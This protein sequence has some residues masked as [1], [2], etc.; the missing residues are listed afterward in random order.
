MI[1]IKVELGVRSY[2]IF[3]GEG[4]LEKLGEMFEIYDLGKQA[5]VL[6]DANV[7]THYGEQLTSSFKD[8]LNA[9]EMITLPAGE[10]SKSLKTVDRVITKM[11][12]LGYERDACVLAF[13]GG[14]IGD[15]AGFVA[16]I[17][18]RGVRFIQ[19]PTTLLAQVDASI[20]GKTGVN[21]PLGKNMIGT[22]Y[23]PQI[24][25]SDLA[26]LK[27]LP[28]RE[29]LCGLAEIIKYGVIKE[30]ELYALVEDNL[31]KILSVD[32]E[33][34]QR[35]VQ[36]CCEIKASIVGEDERDRGLRMILNFGH[37]VGHAL[38]AALGY[39]K[40]SHG[41]AVLLG[42]L[43]ESKIALD[44]MMLSAEDFARIQALITRLKIQTRLKDL[45][46]VKLYEALNKDKKKASGQV[47]FVL[48]KKIG[49][50][51]VVDHVETD[52]V[53]SG[54]AYILTGN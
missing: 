46:E 44:L 12:E 43:A 19:V 36:R 27:T 15:I 49:E 50:A 40:I 2:P 24:V 20:G 39:K 10:K 33:L 34:L 48:P 47:R 5:V 14:V 17:Y 41:E 42:M 9:F 21:H 1:T 7:Q 23:Q 29:I 53:T 45:D 4:I 22:F 25:W 18:K 51:A 28:K 54:I 6:T 26:L 11:L 37:T 38:E 52:K 32:P 16:S 30:P 8:F 35:I 3:V 13:G 31:E